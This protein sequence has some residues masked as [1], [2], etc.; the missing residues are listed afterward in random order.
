MVLPSILAVNL[1][2]NKSCATHMTCFKGIMLKPNKK[3]HISSQ[4]VYKFRNTMKRKRSCLQDAIASANLNLQRIE[5]ILWNF[6]WICNHHWRFS[7]F[8]GIQKHFHD[9]LQYFRINQYNKGKYFTYRRF[10][11]ACLQ[12]IENFYISIVFGISSCLS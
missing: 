8:L 4:I 10:G 1:D 12:N 3:N 11:S 6:S 7:G 2:R 5:L 9:Y